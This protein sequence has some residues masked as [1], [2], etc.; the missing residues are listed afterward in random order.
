MHP[1]EPK[2]GRSLSGVKSHA[3]IIAWASQSLKSQLFDTQVVADTPWSKV[4]K[5]RTQ[6]G[7]FY[8]KQPVQAFYLEVDVIHACADLG[9]KAF[10]PEVV[11]ENA[12]MHC[13]LMKASGDTTVRGVQDPGLRGGLFEQS[14]DVYRNMQ[15]VTE[16]H[17]PRLLSIGVPD[18]RL[19]SLPGLYQR[20]ID[21]HP[22][23]RSHRMD[24]SQ[25]ATLQRLTPVIS[26]MTIELGSYKLPACLNQSDFHDN[27]VVW[28]PKTGCLRLIDLGES[29]ID[30]PFF[31]LASTL[32]RFCQRHHIESGSRQHQR[33]QAAC[34]EGWLAS[35]VD[36]TRAMAIVHKLLPLYSVLAHQR[37]LDATVPSEMQ[38]ITRMRTRI[39]D[40]LSDLMSNLG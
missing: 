29:T 39:P 3:D 36:M 28:N 14:M 13:F 27:N 6:D 17:I 15:K 1:K 25:I 24:S 30:H 20:M 11:D 40:A 35:F 31:S 33:L 22:F 26:D 7:D 23:M 21:N 2:E 16:A 4:L 9:F 32:R 38:K 12:K 8:L 10:L 37:L 19:E 5:L 18:W 34:F